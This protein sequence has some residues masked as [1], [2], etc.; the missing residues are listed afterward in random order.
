MGR[1]GETDAGI[2]KSLAFQAN[3]MKQLG[4]VQSVPASF[5]QYVDSSFAVRLA[6]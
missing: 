4:Q 6:A 5:A 2:Y 1:P 3:F